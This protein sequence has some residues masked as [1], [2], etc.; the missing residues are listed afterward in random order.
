MKFTWKL[1]T[2]LRAKSKCI[3][4]H[5]NLNLPSSFHHRT[6]SKHQLAFRTNKRH[7]NSRVNNHIQ[8]YHP[9][10]RHLSS[11]FKRFK[12]NS[13]LIAQYLTLILF[14]CFILVSSKRSRSL[15][16]SKLW[17][18]M[19]MMLDSYISNR[20]YLLSIIIYEF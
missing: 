17:I 11:S 8:Q 12:F 7:S 1:N 19:C 3:D 18:H 5:S 10:K 6:T 13:F 20:Y 2:N 16:D 4:H 9:I 14:A 15:I